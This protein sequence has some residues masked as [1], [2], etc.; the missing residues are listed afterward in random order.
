[1]SGLGTGTWDLIFAS[2]PKS[3]VGVADGTVVAVSAGL[4]LQVRV[5]VSSGEA[6]AVAELV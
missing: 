4:G 5:A 3:D 6:V 1:M 2:P